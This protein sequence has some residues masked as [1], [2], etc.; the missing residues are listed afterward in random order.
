M[1]KNERN[2]LKKTYQSYTDRLATFRAIRKITS[3]YQF[4]FSKY[5]VLKRTK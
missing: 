1:I 2:M 5:V 3:K 4:F